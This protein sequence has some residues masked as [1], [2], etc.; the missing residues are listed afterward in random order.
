MTIQDR[1]N[2]L[3]DLT[4]ASCYATL[5]ARATVARQEQEMNRWTQWYVVQRATGGYY[6]VVRSLKGGTEDDDEFLCSV[7]GF[8]LS[9]ASGEQASEA[10][11]KANNPWRWYREAA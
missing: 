10:A 11:D 6:Y 4:Q 5:T 7:A 1:I 8:R 3:V 2:E 9:F